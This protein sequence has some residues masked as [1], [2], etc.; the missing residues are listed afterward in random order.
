MR[1]PKRKGEEDRIAL[2]EPEDRHLTPAT[3]E[4][5]KRE[6]VDLETRERGEAVVE[7]RRLAEMG[8]FSEN[9][10][11]QNAKAHLRRV[12][13]RIDTLKERIK[14]AIPIEK[15]TNSDGGIQIGSRV[16]LAMSAKGG[17]TSGGNGKLMEFEIVGSQET[18]PSRGRI[19]YRSPLGQTLLGHKANEEIVFDGP[20][21]KVIYQILEVK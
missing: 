12:N 10:G 19:S 6:L 7:L 9:F 20:A 8:D 1:I 17:S 5:F 16:R 18:N 13:A 14:L 11:Y 15:G 2:S 21:G 3:I 4:R